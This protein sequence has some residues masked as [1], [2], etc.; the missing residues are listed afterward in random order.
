MQDAG[1][2]EKFGAFRGRTFLAKF[3]DQIKKLNP[4]RSNYKLQ[5]MSGGA[6]GF[7]SSDVGKYKKFKEDTG[8]PS[9]TGL[10]GAH[11]GSKKAD[12]VLLLQDEELMNVDKLKTK[13]YYKNGNFTPLNSS[14]PKPVTEAAPAKSE[15]GL[16]PKTHDNAKDAAS[17]KTG[18]EVAAPFTLPEVPTDALSDEPNKVED[19]KVQMAMAAAKLRQRLDPGVASK[20]A[21]PSAL[22]AGASKPQ[23]EVENKAKRAIH[24]HKRGKTRVKQRKVDTVPLLA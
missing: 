6:E 16:D 9:Y 24:K 11:M 17:T 1:S 2:T 18:T 20:N 23:D 12:Q 10:T 21:P 4:R 3:K 22:P 13:D 8:L 15:K 19:K 5:N 14:S 7:T